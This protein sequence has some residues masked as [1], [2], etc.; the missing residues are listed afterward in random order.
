M[1]FAPMRF[2]KIEGTS[3]AV[4]VASAEKAKGALK[5]LRY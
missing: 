5:E 1:R 3:V 2:I 4:T